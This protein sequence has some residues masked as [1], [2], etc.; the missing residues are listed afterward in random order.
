MLPSSAESSA[1]TWQGRSHHSARLPKLPNKDQYEFVLAT[2]LEHWPHTPYQVKKTHL[3]GVEVYVI[4]CDRY[5]DRPELYA[6]HNRAYADNG[7]RFGF[8]AAASLD[9][10]PKLG[11]KLQLFTRMIGTQ[12]LSHSCLRLVTLKMSVFMVLSQY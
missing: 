2:E 12:V 9:V 1:R 10:L 3:D 7:E 6:E 8:F 11:I 5:F 4:E